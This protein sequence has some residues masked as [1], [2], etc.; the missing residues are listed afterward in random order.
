MTLDKLRPVANILLE[1]A[2][3]IA[4]TVGLTPNLVSI[5]A[6]GCATIAGVAFGLGGDLQLWYIIGAAFVFLNG[7]LDLMDGALARKQHV[8]SARGDLLDHVLD[9]YA[10]IVIVAGLTV[11]TGHWIL[12][13]AAVTGVVMTSYLGTQAIAVGFD[14]VYGGLLGRADRLALIGVVGVAVVIYP[15]TI[16]G[17]DLIGWLLLVLAVIG[18]LTAM[19]RFI[20]AMRGMDSS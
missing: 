14:R 2:V 7:W 6:F 5:L 16:A 4:D 20:G 13:F 1:P 17:F 8:A 19:Q 12:G 9:R 11:G 10:D 3:D 18:H 15:D